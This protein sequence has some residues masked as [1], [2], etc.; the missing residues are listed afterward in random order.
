LWPP[1]LKFLA[2]MRVDKVKVMP[3]RGKKFVRGS[4]GAAAG[5]LTITQ[6]LLIAQADL[7]LDV[8]L[9]A[10]AGVLVQSVLGADGEF[11]LVIASGAPGE[12]DGGLQAIVAALVNASTK[13]LAVVDG[14]VED[15]VTG[16]VAEGEVVDLKLAVL[17]VEA[18]LVASEPS[19]VADNSGSVDQWTGEVDVDVSVQA[20]ALM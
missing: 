11:V 13:V 18:E 1:L 10:D 20:D 19:L 16:G 12:V 7:A 5:Q 4:R 17:G 2:S 6:L 3:E 8:N 9:G 15:E 14:S